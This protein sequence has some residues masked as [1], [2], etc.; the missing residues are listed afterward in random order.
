MNIEKPIFEKIVKESSCIT[1]ALKKCGLRA[2]GGNFKTFKK[3]VAKW[4]IDLSHFNA[5]YIRV[6]KLKA[7][8]FKKLTPL[9]DVLVEKSSYS[10]THLKERLYREGLK[11]RKCEEC[12]QSEEWRGKKISLILDHIN[13]KW[14]DNRLENIRI[15][16]PNCNATLDTHCGKNRKKEENKSRRKI[17]I[18]EKKYSEKELERFKQKRKVERPPYEILKKEVENFGYLPTG[19]KYGV[20]DNAIRKWIKTYEKLGF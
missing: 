17:Q 8:N 9:K 12:G 20:S 15:L 13:G 4:D 10:R 1:E 16:C 6:T 3:V 7:L 11:E 5:N 14:D 18:G 2:A 19:K